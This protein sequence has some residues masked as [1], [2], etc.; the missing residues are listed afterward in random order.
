MSPRA[1]S[2]SFTRPQSSSPSFTSPRASFSSFS[3]P[4]VASQSTQ[5]LITHSDYRTAYSN[6]KPDTS[7]TTTPSISGA[8]GGKEGTKVR[9]KHAPTPAA[10]A[11]GEAALRRWSTAKE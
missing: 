6:S 3:S 10:K 1:S 7:G 9:S 11:A 8:R 5:S 2:V 4:Q